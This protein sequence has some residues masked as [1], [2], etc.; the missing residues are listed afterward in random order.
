MTYYDVDEMARQNQEIIK[1]IKNHFFTKDVGRYNDAIFFLT[2]IF[3]EAFPKRLHKIVFLDIDLVFKEDILKLYKE[4]S[5]FEKD[6]VMGIGPD[7][8]PQY[9]IDFS[10]YRSKNQNTTVGSPRPGMQGFNTGVVLFD[11]DRMRKSHLYNSLL[12]ATVLQSLC[13]KYEFDGYLGHQDFFT[14]TGMEYP[15]LYYKLDCSWNRQLDVGWRNVVDKNIF[16]DYHKCE[17]KINIFHA[18]G[19]SI[20]PT[21]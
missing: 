3:H 15:Q 9:R 13:E 1:T 11:L 18:N 20:I 4:F 16:E 5:K 2:E 19:D 6:N 21:T 8:Q 12:N 17:G 7:L 14:L 10:K